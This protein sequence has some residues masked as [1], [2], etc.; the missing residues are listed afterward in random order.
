MLGLNSVGPRD[1]HVAVISSDLGDDGQGVAGCTDAG[2]GAASLGEQC[3]LDAAF[4]VDTPLPRLACLGSDGDCVERNYTGPASDR[5]SCMMSA[6]ASSCPVSQPLEAM[7][8][9]LERDAAKGDQFLR[10]KGHLLVVFVLGGDD[11]ST[12][13]GG[14]VDGPLSCAVD[15]VVCAGEALPD[16]AGDYA[17]C[18][19]ASAPSHLAP[20]SD[21]VDFLAEFRGGFGQTTV[22]VNAA[23]T[24]SISIV[25]AGDGGLA[26]A[27]ICTEGELAGATPAI[28]MASFVEK[29]P[30]VSHVPSSCQA[31]G[32]GSLAN[33]ALWVDPPKT[34]LGVANVDGE[35]ID[36][37]DARERCSVA[38]S[39]GKQEEP[40]AP[41]EVN[42]S[43][44]PFLDGIQACWWLSNNED[45]E[46]TALVRVERIAWPP[47]GTET[48]ITCPASLEFYP[49]NLGTI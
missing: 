48:W 19:A 17:S 8:V 4:L 2:A 43:G 25:G 40:I 42:D 36:I 18:T 33:F 12:D 9:A 28:R 37:A 6:G 27:P 46:G 41:C 39:L 26:L 31:D 32:L 3:D 20:V 7:R 49:P 21:Y 38:D 44:E 11:C 30:L 23:T 1:L 22:A 13:D 34:T 24:D 5:I 35:D 47:D 45:R 16:A 10:K 29:M 15:G 14:D